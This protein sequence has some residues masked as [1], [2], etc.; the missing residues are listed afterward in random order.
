MH[1]LIS[2]EFLDRLAAELDDGTTV[3]IALMGSHARG[4]PTPYSDVDLL[5]FSGRL[6]ESK[7]QSYTLKR[8]EG[9]LVS[10]MTTTI[11]ARR[12]ELSR[13]EQAIWAVP[14]L[15]QGRILLDKRGELARLKQEADDF[16][17]EPLQDA[18]DEYAS[19]N[20]MGNAEE[21]HK[22]LGGLSRGDESAMLYGTLGLC[23]NL[24][25]IVAVQRGLLIETENAFFRKVQQS[26]GQASAWT[27]WFRLAVGF[28]PTPP[29]VTPAQARA[30]AGLRLYEETASMLW[31]VLR[32]EHTE[33][34][35]LTLEAIRRAELPEP[36]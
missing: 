13:P 25:T 19:Y 8:R 27:R 2:K 22:V 4:D 7:A 30:I 6:P 16:R 21:V 36:P 23:L 5:R 35:E 9:R 15:R 11:A 18:A 31:R 24:P 14:G 29:A 12:E 17:W 32:P 28:D 34:V 1:T 20:L 26:A 33:V 10:V 3:A